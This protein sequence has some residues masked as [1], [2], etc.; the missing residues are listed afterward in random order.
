MEDGWT[1]DPFEPEIRDGKIFGRG[2]IDDKGPVVAALY[3]MKYVAENTKVNKKVRLIV[4]LNEEKDWECI[5][6]YKQKE[7]YPNIGFSPDADFP[8]IYAEKGIVTVK[9]ESSYKLDNCEILEFDTGNNA[10]NVV[11]KYCSVKIKVLDTEAKNKLLNVNNNDIYVEEISENVLKINAHGIAAHAA[12]PDLGDNAI[13]KLLEFLGNIDYLKQEGIFDIQSPKYLGGDSTI[14]ESGKLTSNIGQIEYENGRL[15]LYTNL[16]VPV[17][18]SFEVIEEY[19]KE[20]KQR[21]S[22]IDYGMSH[23]NEKLYVS[24]ESYLVKTLTKIFNEETGLNAEPVAIGGGTYA[25][26]FENCI[27]FGMT[28]PGDKD[29]CHQVDEFVDIDKLILSAKIYAKAIIELTN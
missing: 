10:I 25:R 16:R 18:T 11:P 22:D 14:D 4:G 26:A 27:S 20:L 13:T 1:S 7:E 3:A 19:L 17:N 28:M 29:M 2:T 6:Y 23:K 5:N 24:K 21:N 15:K 9:M 8:C 12:H